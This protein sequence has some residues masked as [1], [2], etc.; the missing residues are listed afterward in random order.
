MTSAQLEDASAGPVAEGPPDTGDQPKVALV[1]AAHPDDPDFGAAGTAHLWSKLGWDFYYLVC[2]DGSK[3]TEDASLTAER[4]VPMRQKEQRAAAQELGVKDVLFL[5]GHV[6]GELTHNRRLLGDV[7][8]VIR[9]LKP[10]AVFTHEP[11]QIFH[12]ESFI[13]HSDHRAT[14]LVTIDAVYPAARDR[15][16]FPEQ[17]E[18]GLEPHKVKEVFI[19]GNDNP[20]F[21]V[22]ITDAVETKI[23]ALLRHTSQFGEG[24][25]E[26]LKFVRERWKDKDGK[27]YERFKRV[28]LAR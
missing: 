20:N 1:V 19:W 23:Q 24:T 11:T 18:E 10:Y 22:D 17:I 4:L 25:N 28:T 9:Q 13:N 27:Y 6:D 7:V 5:E 3:G 8:R 2:T 12:R 26:F 15:W 21:P 16:N 14:G